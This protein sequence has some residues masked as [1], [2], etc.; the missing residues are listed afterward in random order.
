MDILFEN[1][2]NNLSLLKQGGFEKIKNEINVFLLY[3]G[4]QV[5]IYDIKLQNILHSGIFLGVN[6]YGHAI[7]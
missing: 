3:K 7:L 4:M 1:L 6:E 5:N 2:I